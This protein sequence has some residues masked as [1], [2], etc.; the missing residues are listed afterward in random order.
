MENWYLDGLHRP[1]GLPTVMVLFGT[2]AP[3]C[4][5]LLQRGLLAQDG[6]DSSPCPRKGKLPMESRKQRTLQVCWGQETWRE[7]C[8]KLGGDTNL[9]WELP[10]STALVPQKSLLRLAIKHLLILQ[11]S[12]GFHLQTRVCLHFVSLFA[13]QWVSCF[14]GEE[15]KSNQCKAQSST[16][17]IWLLL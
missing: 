4:H 6:F 10:A 7:G 14:W 15:E 5:I 9:S 2:L 12:R 8:T 13:L 17:L 11:G 1:R 3:P 16:E